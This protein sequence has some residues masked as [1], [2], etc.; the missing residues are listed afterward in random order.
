MSRLGLLGLVCL[1]AV[2]PAAGAA[3]AARQS[4]RVVT[5]GP[6]RLVSPGFGYVVAER[7]VPGA[8]SAKTQIRLFVYD[9]GHWRD[10]SPAALRSPA[11]PR[12]GVDA[13]DDVDFVSSR[14]GWLA[15]FNC[16]L[17]SVHL[18]R[19]SDGGR[20]WRSL[21]RPDGHSC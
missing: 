4:Q 9:H 11:F 18:Y 14:V 20:T 1:A 2:L 12:D 7:F 21:G 17:A 6:M 16:S 5:I 8:G 13:V 15:T 10:A 19:T 3:S